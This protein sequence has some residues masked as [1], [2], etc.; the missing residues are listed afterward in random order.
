MINNL[1]VSYDF[2]NFVDLLTKLYV[3]NDYYF[4]NWR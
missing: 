4:C 3:Q 1:M 2:R